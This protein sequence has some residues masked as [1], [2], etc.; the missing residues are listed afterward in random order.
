MTIH[1][2]LTTATLVIV[3]STAAFAQATN[4]LVGTWK[5]NA[6]KSKGS[7]Y[8]GGGTKVEAVGDGVK[9][10]VELVAQDGKEVQWG[11]TA[12]YDGQD[13]KMTGSNPYGD[14][15][16]LTRVDARTT[17][18]SNQAGGEADRLA[19]HH[20]FRGREDADDDHQGGRRERAAGRRPVLLRK[21]IAEVDKSAPPWSPG[22]SRATTGAGPAGARSHQSRSFRR[23]GAGFVLVGQPKPSTFTPSRRIASR[24]RSLW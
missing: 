13:V 3:A 18:M 11:F 4:P 24:A 23:Q 22:A 16:A 20:R 17:R 8:K 5:L 12:K 2:F 7:P 6:A 1:R 14:T 15:I 21:A 19:G 9:F 10:T